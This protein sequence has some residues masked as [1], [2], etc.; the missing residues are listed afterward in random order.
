MDSRYATKAEEIRALR[1]THRSVLVVAVFGINAV[2][3]VEA[4]REV[5]DRASPRAWANYQ[6]VLAGRPK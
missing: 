6:K 5:F 4:A 3:F 1:G 2:L